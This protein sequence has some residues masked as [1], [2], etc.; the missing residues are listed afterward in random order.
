[1]RRTSPEGEPPGVGE[2]CPAFITR[3]SWLAILPES[4][5][6]AV[7]GNATYKDLANLDRG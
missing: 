7:T 3:R 6:L 4:Y 5:S 1:M 2:I